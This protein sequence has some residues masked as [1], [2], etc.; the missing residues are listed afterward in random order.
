MNRFIF[1]LL[2][3]LSC[4]LAASQATDP[5]PELAVFDFRNSKSTKER[6]NYFLPPKR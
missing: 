4:S 6:S 3:L 2:I 5:Q 1:A